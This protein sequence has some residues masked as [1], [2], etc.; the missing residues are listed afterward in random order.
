MVNDR[1]TRFLKEFVQ[2]SRTVAL[3]WIPVS[4]SKGCLRA[5]VT[6]HR[7]EEEIDHCS[8]SV[9]GSEESSDRS[10]AR[11]DCRLRSD[12]FADLARL[13]AT[14]T[15]SAAGDISA[16]RV[17]C[18]GAAQ[19]RAAS[20]S[21]KSQRAVGAEVDQSEWMADCAEDG[22]LISPLWRRVGRFASEMVCRR[23]VQMEADKSLNQFTIGS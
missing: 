15:L 14:H 6:E 20:M 7:G 17:N 10:V 12:R 5:I 16:R 21:M 19:H 8:F 2:S 13:C 23:M 18:A 3:F 11:C 22:P 1:L 9:S 4:H